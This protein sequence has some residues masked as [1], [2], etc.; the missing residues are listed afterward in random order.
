M[1]VERE[2]G[3]TLRVG[4][5]DRTSAERTPS[6]PLWRIPPGVASSFAPYVDRVPAPRAGENDL[7]RIAPGRQAASGTRIE[8]S[9]RLSDDRGRPIAQAL[10]ELWNANRW[11]R[12]THEDDPAREPLDPNFVG[13]GRTLTDADGR[14]SFLTI[15]PGAYLARPDIGRW[16]PRHLHFS[17]LGKA[18]RLIT[19]M[20]FANDPYNESDPSFILLGDGGSRH[21]GM[22]ATPMQPGVDE[23]YG[24]D[25]VVGGRCGVVFETID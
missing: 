22:Q 7:T 16:R 6:S 1:T 25:L 2:R 18:A 19:Q 4:P 24:F 17:I 3:R 14:Y 12:Y 20:Y 13:I 10:I 5:T 21:V 15:K 11:G 9:G 8:V 23:A